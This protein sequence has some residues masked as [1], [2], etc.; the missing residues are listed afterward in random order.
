[1]KC[2]LIFVKGFEEL[3]CVKVDFLTFQNAAFYKMLLLKTYQTLILFLRFQK[4]FLLEESANKRAL[5]FNESFIKTPKK[6]PF[7][8]S[9]FYASWHSF[10]SQPDVQT[11]AIILAL[12]LHSV[13]HT[14]AILLLLISPSNPVSLS[15]SLIY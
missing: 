6:Y 4:A 11:Y 1:M 3:P 10:F 8:L 2:A 14:T 12:S 7:N 5:R 15:I 13:A 9:P